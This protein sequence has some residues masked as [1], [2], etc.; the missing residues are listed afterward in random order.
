MHLEVYEKLSGDHCKVACCPNISSEEERKPLKPQSG[1]LASQL[2]E[3]KYKPDCNHLKQ[4]S[5]PDEGATFVTFNN[6]LC[7]STC[8]A[9]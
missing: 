9:Y 3:F 1:L 6:S 4:C 7:G 2:S 8:I 5:A